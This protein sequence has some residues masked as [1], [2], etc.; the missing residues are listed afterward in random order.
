M[1]YG[2]DL[3]AFRCKVS[4]LLDYLVINLDRPIGFHLETS[5]PLVGYR[6]E[7]RSTKLPNHVVMSRR[8]LLTA[9]SREGTCV[10]H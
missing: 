8:R 7:T 10:E 6:I 1:T 2:K 3:F 5:R 4:E 9:Y